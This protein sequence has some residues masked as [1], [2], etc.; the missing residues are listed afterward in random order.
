MQV[1]N[2]ISFINW[3]SQSESQI[4][5]SRRIIFTLTAYQHWITQ[6]CE[7]PASVSQTAAEPPEL[8]KERKLGWPPLLNALR[9]SG[10]DVTKSLPY[11]EET[12]R[13]TLGLAGLSL[14]ENPKEHTMKPL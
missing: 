4:F 12:A 1:I 7:V 3:L 8:D 10:G 2:F 9:I 5:P 6:E 11:L 14:V 13:E